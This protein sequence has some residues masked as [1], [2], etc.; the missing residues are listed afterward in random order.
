MLTLK[1]PHTLK[2]NAQV[3]ALAMFMSAKMY[4]ALMVTM[5]QDCHFQGQTQVQR[6]TT[7]WAHY[8]HTVSYKA[9]NFNTLTCD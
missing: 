9:A 3:M 1:N 8:V 4:K 2:S 7:V 6:V 5:G